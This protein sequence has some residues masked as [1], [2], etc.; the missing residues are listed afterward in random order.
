MATPRRLEEGHEMESIRPETRND[1]QFPSTTSPQE[2]IPGSSSARQDPIAS[3]F[4]SDFELKK[5]APNGWPQIAATQFY[6]TNFNI[7]RRFSYLLQRTLLDQETKLAYLENKLKEL[8]KED[9]RYNSS[10]LTSLPFDPETLLSNYARSQ[11]A[12]I[13]PIP[14]ASRVGD[15][16]QTTSD[17][18]NKW[19]DKDL[20]LESLIPRLKEY[21]KKMKK[22]PSISRKEHKAFYKE[23]KDCNTLDNAAYEFLF[24]KDDFITTITDRVHQYFEAF[25]Y[26]DSPVISLMKKILGRTPQNDNQDT[27][28]EIVISNRG[29]EVVFKILLVFVSGL[30]MLSP[31]AIL[32][33]ANLP[34]G[35][36]FGVVVVFSFAFVVVLALL[37]SNWETIL[38]GL[39]AYMAVLATFLSNLEQGKTQIS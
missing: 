10:R 5:E 38:V 19:K 4:R 28:P 7:H 20:I 16:Q 37:N 12:S 1:P 14:T 13:R 6:Y 34:R 27:P 39:S 26:G 35:L 17:E 33:L 31:V 3:N 8:D 11:P 32:F 9:E 23:V 30:L 36:S 2:E 25:I 18:Y 15:T 22:L 29:L 24:S 21:C